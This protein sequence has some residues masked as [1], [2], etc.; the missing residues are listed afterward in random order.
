MSSRG[1]WSDY[2]D[3][4]ILPPPAVRDQAIALSRQLKKYGGRFVLGKTRFLPHI[5][6]AHI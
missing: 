1:I 4:V 3:V 5:S 6:S 2:F